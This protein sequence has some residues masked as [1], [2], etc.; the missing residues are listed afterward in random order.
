MASS[1][2]VL[3]TGGNTGIGRATAEALAAQGHRLW[4]AGRSE[5]RTRPVLD[6][7]RARGARA[8]F[9]PLDL[10]D[11][12]SVRACAARFVATGERLDVLLANAGLAGQRGETKQGFELAFGTNHLGHFLLTE[13]LL[14]RLEESGRAGPRARVVVV[15]SRAHYRV[16]NFDWSTLRGPT[17]TFTGWPEYQRSKLC[18]V[19]FVRELARRLEGKPVDAYALHPGVVASDIWRRAPR[20][21]RALARLWMVSNEE[22]A[23]TSVYCATAP[24]LEGKSGRYW[25][26]CAEKRPSRL[27]LD[28]ALAAELWAKSEAWTR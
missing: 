17:R 24:E 11:L 19:L 28:D 14:P 21:L 7:V 16:R 1:L 27:A 8:D 2:H 12:G 3:L 5:E 25:H 9:L 4:L 23:Q 22:G 6:A 15:A 10:A 13:L 20:P 18:N 26:E